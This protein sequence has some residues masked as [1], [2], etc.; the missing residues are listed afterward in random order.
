MSGILGTSSHNSA[1]ECYRGLLAVQHRGQ[2]SAGILSFNG[3][4]HLKRKGLVLSVFNKEELSKL[5]GFNAIGHVRY[6]KTGTST[7]SEAQPFS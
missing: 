7:L 1:Y 4:V 5:E 6:L 2:D 3:I